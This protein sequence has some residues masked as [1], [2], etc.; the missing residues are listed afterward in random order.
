MGTREAAVRRSSVLLAIVVA[1]LLAALVLGAGRLAE[2]RATA[3]L[4][5]RAAAALPLATASL[6]A[7]IE[8]Q[9]LV[10]TVL[11]R[12]PEVIALLFAPIEPARAPPRRQARRDRRG[13]RS[14]R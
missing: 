3:E 8:K 9:R 14:R 10:P 7:V 12:D 6:A 2:R 13:R 1:A 5:G 4:A 11:A